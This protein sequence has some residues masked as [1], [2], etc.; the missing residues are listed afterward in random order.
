MQDDINSCKNTIYAFGMP[1][2]ILK[3]IPLI[4]KK[5]NNQLF[6]PK[7]GNSLP[8]INKH[9]IGNLESFTLQRSLILDAIEGRKNTIDFAGYIDGK[10]SRP[11]YQKSDTFKEGKIL[12][13]TKYNKYVMLYNRLKKVGLDTL[14]FRPP[15]LLRLNENHYARLD[16]IHRIGFMIYLQF[17]ICDFL[18]FD[19]SDLKGEVLSA[20]LVRDIYSQFDEKYDEHVSSKKYH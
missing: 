17:D 4:E 8:K 18:V 15:I 10:I 20:E 12:N 19:I 7:H 1:R 3:Q 16:G 6:I 13:E 2:R 11:D 9:N 5:A 14:S